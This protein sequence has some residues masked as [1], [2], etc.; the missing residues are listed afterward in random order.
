MERGNLKSLKLFVFGAFMMIVFIACVLRMFTLKSKILLI[1]AAIASPLLATIRW[2]LYRVDDAFLL[3][4]AWQNFSS[5]SDAKKRMA[6]VIT[7]VGPS[8]SITS[9]TNILA[10]AVGSVT[11][12]PMMSSFCF[13]MLIAVAIDYVLELT[14]FAP[15]LVIAGHFKH[16]DHLEKRRSYSARRWTLLSRFV[17]S[18]IGLVIIVAMQITLYIIATVGVMSMKASFDPSKTFSSDSK[19]ITC[20]KI[21]DSI[22]REYAPASFVVN[23]PPDISNATQYNEFM[24]MVKKLEDLPTS[25]GANRT[26]L[27]LRD[28]VKYVE[29]KRKRIGHS[30]I[31]L[32][33]QYVPEFLTSK[34]L[35]DKNVLHYH[36]VN[37]FVFIMVSCGIGGWTE[38]ANF[39]GPIRT[40]LDQY[41]QYNITLFDY[42][43][44][45]FDLISSVKV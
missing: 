11:A 15:M 36:I 26:L 5:I 40:V 19:L 24:G 3:T 44:T 31:S 21:V 34:F 1:A 22:Y 43:G 29:N 45:I 28:Y 17:V 23:N 13:C 20:V 8:I 4:H 12:P 10:F 2:D 39:V 6:S 37:S 32:S 42:D 30:N 33:Y 16:D 27:W 41:P 35:A 25:Y 18:K 14:V 7:A 9:V 38:R